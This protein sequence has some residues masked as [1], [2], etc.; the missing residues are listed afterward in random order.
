MIQLSDSDDELDKSSDV[1]A[2]GFIVACVASGSKEEEEEEGEMLLERKKGS[3][4]CAL[5]AGRF[6]GSESKDVLGSKLPPPLPPFAPPI[7]PF[8]PV[9]LKKRKKDKERPKEGELVP[10]TEGVPLKLP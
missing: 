7:N 9:N 6:K 5:L 1:R 8:T 3:S 2:L 10:Y 4:L